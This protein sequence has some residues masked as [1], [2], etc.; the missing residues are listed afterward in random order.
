MLKAFLAYYRPHRTLFLVDF[1]C[2][3]LS[4]LLELGFPLAVKAFVDRLLPQQ[5]W[6]LILLA[7]MGLTLL[8][9]A[10]AGLMVVVTYWGHVL[11]INIETEMRARA[12]DH[13]QKLS[14]R[15][16]D[17]QKTGHLVARI[18]KDL[19]EIGEVAHHGPEDLFIAVMTL[20]GAFAL[21]F[22]VHPPLA[23]MTL[24]ILPLI[25]FI[26]IRYGGRMTRNWQAQ[27]GRVGAF[28]ARIEENVGG[29]RVV[30]AF[31]NE[32]H[33]RALFASDNRNYRTT[34]LEAYRLM[35]GALSINYL[36]LRLVQIVVL[37]G[38]A[39]F[40]VRGDLTPGGFVGF[41]LLVAVFYRPL[42]KIGAV[43]ET[44]PKGIA[45]FRR[46]QDLLATEPDI[47][48]RPGAIPAPPLKG[49]IRFEGVRFGYS[50]DR[51]VLSAIDLTIHAGETVAFVGPSGAGKT[52]LLSLIPRFYEAETGRITIDGHDIRDLTL[53]SL[54]GQI[55]IVQQDVFLF[56]GTIR[57]NIAYGRLRAS[58]AEILDAAARARLDG[59]I[60]SLPE[61]LDTVIGE[62]GVKLSGGQKQRLAIARAFLKNPPILILDEA[63][64]ALDTQTE[65]EIQASLFELAEGRTTLVI[66]HR[67]A[68]IRHADRIVVVAEN[69]IVEQGRH[70]VLLAGD[71]YYRRLHAAQVEDSHPSR[72]RTAAE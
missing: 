63:T 16:F 69:G 23:L 29:I 48:D 33:E 6:S 25:A 35:A 50:P 30:K 24:A 54:R 34:K 58:E 21:M 61:G 60:A 9:V 4:G 10:N 59:L 71:G 43:I 68:T 14:F 18:T 66:A 12:F 45:G 51:P 62:R 38:G 65:R 22:L 53:A 42:E 39:A 1:G 8:Y 3:V 27:Y 37:L 41:L 20:F 28:N 70:D 15:F 26:V 44:Y 55:G 17:G 2:A 19:E 72:P 56:A 52:T 64:S 57:E 11:G 36:G 47:A 40:V 46:Y 67:L 31:A 32:A 5:D 49:E 13:L 7:A